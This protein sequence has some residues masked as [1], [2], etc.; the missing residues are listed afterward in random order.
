MGADLI[1]D[2]PCPAPIRYR[3]GSVLFGFEV[4]ISFEL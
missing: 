2:V 3:F 1:G 4:G